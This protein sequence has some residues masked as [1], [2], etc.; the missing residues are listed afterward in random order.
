[1]F[2]NSY[3]VSDSVLPNFLFIIF[4]EIDWSDHTNPGCLVI[5][6]ADM[7]KIKYWWHIDWT[8]VIPTI[9]ICKMIISTNIFIHSFIYEFKWSIR[10]MY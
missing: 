5:P 1:M 4:W 3:S 2:R 7:I 9:E 10:E 6:I 8:I